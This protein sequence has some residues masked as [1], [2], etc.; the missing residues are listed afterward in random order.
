MGVNPPPAKPAAVPKSAALV[1]WTTVQALAPAQVG[2][3]HPLGRVQS[4]AIPRCVSAACAAAVISVV[5]A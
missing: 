4:Q 1:P 5:V 2:T 3:A